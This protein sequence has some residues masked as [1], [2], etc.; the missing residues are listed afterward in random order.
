MAIRTRH[1]RLGALVMLALAGVA[2]AQSSGGDYGITR[3]VIAGGGTRATGGD[4]SV[5]TTAGAAQV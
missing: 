3:E 4:Y 2:A 5:V 1:G